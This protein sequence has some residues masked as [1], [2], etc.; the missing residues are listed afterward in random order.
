[1]LGVLLGLAAAIVWGGSDFTGGL[2]MRRNHPLVVM[3]MASLSGMLMLGI[4]ALVLREGLPSAA[5]TGW[6]AAAGVGGA[7]AITALYRGLATGNAAEVAPVAAVIGAVIPVA[8]GSWMQGWP[9][10]ALPGVWLVSR[11]GSASDRRP[12]SGFGLACL[13]GVGIGAFLSL[14]AM[15]DTGPVFAP[16]VVARTAAVCGGLILFVVHPLRPT[17]RGR[18]AVVAVSSGD[19]GAVELAPDPARDADA[20]A[21][22]AVVSRRRHADEPVMAA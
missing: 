14:I 12:S 10:P 2:A 22:G 3:V 16:L 20:V 4:F 11:P 8:I 6:A 9:S 1:M 21:R 15:V 13:A 19:G 7:L 17:R 5:N 18:G